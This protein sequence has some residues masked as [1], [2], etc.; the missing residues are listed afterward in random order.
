MKNKSSSGVDGI[1]NKILKC[2]TVEILE[3]VTLIINQ[4]L[5]TGIFPDAFKIAKVILLYK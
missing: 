4:M 3:A 5:K 2:I 1:S